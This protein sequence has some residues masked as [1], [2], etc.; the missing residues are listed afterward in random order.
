MRARSYFAALLFALLA[1][2][3]S[4]AA[5]AEA[6]APHT[7]NTRARHIAAA[8]VTG[9]ITAPGALQWNAGTR[10]YSPDPVRV[11][12]EFTNRG[13]A[14]A[15]RARYV[16]SFDPADFILQ[17][18]A[19]AEQI[20]ASVDLAAFSLESVMWQL[21]PIPRLTADSVRVCVTAR[22]DNHADVVVCTKIW[23]PKADLNLTCSVFAPTI[24]VDDNL[25]QYVPMPFPVTVVVQNTSST[26]SDTVSVVLDLPGDLRSTQ[27]AGLT[28]LEA[29]TN[30]PVIAPGAI[31]QIQWIIQHPITETAREYILRA[32]TSVRG[33]VAGS[34]TKSVTIPQLLL[35]LAV[36][37]LPAGP[38][39]L[40]P[41]GSVQLEAD[42][43]FATYRWSTGETTRSIVAR[44]TGSY[45]VTVTDA[46][47]RSATS[48]A[49]DVVVHP[50]PTPRLAAS[51]ALTFCD[52]ESVQLDAGDGYASYLW[53]TGQTT[54]FLTVGQGG[55]WWATVRT[56]EGCAGGSDT[57]L[58]VVYPSPPQPVI[59]RSGNVLLA[60]A[61]LRHQWYRNGAALPNETN[62]FYVPTE[63][64][65]YTVAIT[66][67]YGCTRHSAPYD[68]P[69]GSEHPQPA[70]AS[71]Q[72]EAYPDPVTDLL[73]IT[74]QGGGG[75]AVEVR[76][77]DLL[78]R[79]LVRATVMPGEAVR[80][81]VLS[82]AT[83]P[84]GAYLLVA[85]AARQTAVHPIR[86][87]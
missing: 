37:I 72:V 65:S 24:T 79:E 13:D 1:H 64:G 40:C 85:S 55:L 8:N 33:M 48:A 70:H 3:I 75:M 29:V 41:G 66:N 86:K 46:Y 60:D 20:G 22:F 4:P 49:V 25:H 68:V 53:N 6:S 28:R 32:V 34:C 27:P 12:A 50:S 11:Q 56:A 62:Q 21:Q 76:M 47:G 43:A 35:P 69:T 71:L 51:G 26:P 78:G 83:L 52:G 23:V 84:P 82:L 59:T 61:G 38:T 5:Q 87:R 7:P 74:L 16:L 45:T 36:R 14:T 57:V 30:P 42:G 15:Q 81:H 73:T 63:P 39:S 10:S 58:T 18:P 44:S 67:E 31:G 80:T 19:T 54:R 2:V 9:T 17:S 77:I